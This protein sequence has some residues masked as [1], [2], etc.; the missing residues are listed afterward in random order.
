MIAFSSWA[1]YRSSREPH[2]LLLS[3]WLF[4]SLGKSCWYSYSICEFTRA[5][6]LLVIQKIIF[7]CRSAQPV[8]LTTPLTWWS[9]ILLGKG[10]WINNPC[11]AE[12]L[13]ISYSL[14]NFSLYINF[15]LLEK[16][17]SLMKSERKH[18]SMFTK[19]RTN[20]HSFIITKTHSFIITAHSFIITVAI[21]F[22]PRV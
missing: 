16:E 17:V 1:R 11:R 19:I 2:P 13:T 21:R 7:H 18:E 14:H 6:V 3:F 20:T 15:H 5:I 4:G 12:Y 8:T 10:Y 22:S 9:L